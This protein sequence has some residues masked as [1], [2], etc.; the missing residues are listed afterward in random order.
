MEGTERAI[1][2]Y[3]DG[4]PQLPPQILILVLERGS[5]VFLFAN[6]TINGHEPVRFF[7]YEL[8]WTSRSFLETP[9]RYVAVDPK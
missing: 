5:L 8:S 3:L 2:A 7:M 6:D 4:G 9:G 1:G